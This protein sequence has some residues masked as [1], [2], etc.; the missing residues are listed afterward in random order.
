VEDKIWLAV[1]SVS[2]GRDALAALSDLFKWW[3]GEQSAAVLTP[4]DWLCVAPPVVNGSASS[5]MH[6]GMQPAPHPQN[7]TNVKDDIVF[8]STAA[9]NHENDSAWTDRYDNP[10]SDVEM[11]LIEDGQGVEDFEMA[12]FMEEW[13]DVPSDE[14]TGNV[15]SEG[16]DIPKGWEEGWE[17]A[18][19]IGESLAS[20]FS[21]LGVQRGGNGMVNPAPT[22]GDGGCDGMLPPPP[23]SPNTLPSRATTPSTV[24]RGTTPSMYFRTR[25]P[26]PPP[27]LT[28]SPPP[29]PTPTMSPRSPS[30]P[31]HT[32]TMPPR[33]PSLPPHTP[34]MS[35]PPPSTPT[36]SPRSPLLPPRTPTMAPPPRIPS[37][38][39]PRGPKRH[40]TSRPPPTTSGMWIPTSA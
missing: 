12:D 17:A 34:T 25:T 1:A 29:P 2:K 21:A 22:G 6:Q 18:D 36:A 31:P 5:Q 35:P 38:S 3:D 30:F 37:P 27:I 39:P 8:G 19:S 11:C 9:L 40:T 13:M 26:S 23:T 15:V 20:A 10:E 7:S 32:P 14:E 33:S 4:T 16:A 28:M 24:P